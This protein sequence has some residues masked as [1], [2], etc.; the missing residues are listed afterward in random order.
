MSH[1]TASVLAAMLAR[2]ILVLDGA[3]GTMVQR[4][5]LA[6][7]D[8]RGTRFAGHRRDLKG[9]NDVLPLT[10]SDL[11][12][13]I[14]DEYLAA[15]LEPLVREMNVAAARVARRA[16]EAW[17]ARTPDRPRFVAGSIGPTNKTLSIS[18]DVS[19]P[20]FRSTTFDRVREAYA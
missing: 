8:F 4:M 6:E 2:R 14:H 3:M 19:D 10:R 15:G 16:A 1:S 13:R 20:S 18:P 11:V 9:N 17:T 7:A 12:E 5:G